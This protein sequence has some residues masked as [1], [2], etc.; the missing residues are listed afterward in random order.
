M[1]TT[2]GKFDFHISIAK[3]TFWQ[4]VRSLAIW[5]GIP[6][7]GAELGG[8]PRDLWGYVVILAVPATAA[9]VIAGAA[10]LHAAAAR[11]NKE[12]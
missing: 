6:A 3:R 9:G 8:V 10:I 2:D 12:K 4:R 11:Q 7:V 5:W 1:T